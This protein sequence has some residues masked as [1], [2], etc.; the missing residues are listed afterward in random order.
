MAVVNQASDGYLFNGG[1]LNP[2]LTLCRGT[3]YTFA[4][5]APL[6]PFYIRN[7]N[8]TSFV[9][10]I[11]GNHIDSGNLVFD[12]PVTAPNMLFYQCDFHDVMTG[13]IIIVD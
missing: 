10:G 4:I 12:V 9:D 7:Q 8:G 5:N 1:P 3:K 2:P 13:A 6:H 11:T